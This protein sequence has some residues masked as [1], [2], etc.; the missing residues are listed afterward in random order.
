[1][2]QYQVPV[3]SEVLQQLFSRDDGLARLV[4]QILNQILAAQVPEQLK[5][6]PYERPEERQGYRSG[7]RQKPLVTRIGRLVLKKIPRVRS[8]EFSPERRWYR[9]LRPWHP[10]Q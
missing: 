4:E 2:A 9:S 6:K 5:A 3:D 1:M 7:H 8:G 10:R